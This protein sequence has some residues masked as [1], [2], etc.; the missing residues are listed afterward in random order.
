[1]RGLI[2]RA[3]GKLKMARMSRNAL[4][5][6]TKIVAV[7]VALAI[8][9]GTPAAQ[10]PTLGPTYT[11]YPTHTPQPTPTSRPTPT[12]TSPPTYT[13]QP[14]H[15][16]QPTRTLSPRLSATPTISPKMFGGVGSEERFPTKTME[17]IR[18]AQL[19]FS[20]GRYREALQGFL[21]TQRI[22]GKDSVVLQSWIAASYSALGEQD[23]A[24]LHLTK[25]LEI[26]DNAVDRASRA[27]SYLSTQRCAPAIED[28]RAA[29]AMEP[30]AREGYH[31]D[32]EAN[33]VLAQCLAQQEEY[34][35]AL[36]HVEEAIEMAQRHHYTDTER[37]T[38]RGLLRDRIQAVVEEREWPEDLI[39]LPAV[40]YFRRGMEL[41]DQ[42]RFEEAIANLEIAQEEHKRPSGM[43]QTEIGHAYSGLGQHEQA[44]R[45]Y[46]LA[47]EIRDDAFH[48]TNRG[49]E[50]LNMENCREAMTD[51]SRAL[52]VKQYEEPGFHTAVDAH[53]ILATCHRE[54]EDYENAIAHGRQVVDLA[55]QHGY[56]EEDISF[57]EEVIADWT[58]T[59]HEGGEQKE[60]PATP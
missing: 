33:I 46:S 53:W 39:L 12:H 56:P 17:E 15:T 38:K 49:M 37:E 32:V 54:E 19:A 43:I 42:G 24:I 21:E 7:A 50:Y 36:Q 10:T 14:T 52:E 48:R 41:N 13:P 34:L 31:S 26:R 9:C 5:R 40:M 59:S 44:I 8:G 45:H 27:S 18:E 30:V 28:A 35:L 11:P 4:A 22:H 1:M 20:E 2:A 60:A 51:A 25:S 58:V 6:S 57:M 47:I 3:V 55:R 16:P 29:L 23:Q